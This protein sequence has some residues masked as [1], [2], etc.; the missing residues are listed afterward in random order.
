M[1][2]SLTYEGFHDII[3]DIIDLQG[4]LKYNINFQLQIER[5]LLRVQEEKI[6]NDKGHRNSV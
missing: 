3:G 6:I 4:Q 5:L 2:K 1:S